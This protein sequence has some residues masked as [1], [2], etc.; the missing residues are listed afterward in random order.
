[1]LSPPGFLFFL[2]SFVQ[3]VAN[4][5]DLLEKIKLEMKQ[6]KNG[7]DTPTELTYQV[8]ILYTFM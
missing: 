3:V 5:P 1:M 7:I 2:L 4:E 6:I 8:C